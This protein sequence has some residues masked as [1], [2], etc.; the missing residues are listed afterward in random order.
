[1]LHVARRCGYYLFCKRN[2]GYTYSWSTWWHNAFDYDAFMG[3]LCNW[4][5]YAVMFI[6]GINIL[7]GQCIH[8]I[9]FDIICYKLNQ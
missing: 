1:M 9:A 2:I 6:V 3:V 8:K 7:I 5:L 4:A